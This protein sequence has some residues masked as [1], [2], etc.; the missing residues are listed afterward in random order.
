MELLEI[1][2]VFVSNAEDF[3]EQWRGLN[4]IV[5]EHLR[6]VELIWSLILL[7][8]TVQS[9][10]TLKFTRYVNKGRVFYVITWTASLSSLCSSDYRRL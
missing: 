1:Y 5:D 3:I 8:F 10:A 7:L 4:E 2:S 6:E 9:V